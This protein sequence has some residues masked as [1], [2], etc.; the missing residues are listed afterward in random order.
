[1][2]PA[3]ME[4]EVAIAANSSN[5]NVLTGELHEVAQFPGL[6][7]LLE[8]GS[9]AGLRSQLFVASATVTGRRIVNS[10]NRTPVEP[11]DVVVQNV[12]VYPGD[13]ITL[14]VENTTVGALTHRCRVVIE[15]GE[16]YE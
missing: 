2:Y 16:I 11:D 1:M 8:T 14:R 3:V 9:A 6:L 10:Q 7:R 15:P 4:T 12:E 5:A 13:K